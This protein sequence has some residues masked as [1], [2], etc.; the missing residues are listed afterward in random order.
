MK[1]I[2]TWLWNSENLICANFIYR[3]YSRFWFVE[4]T[5]LR[6]NLIFSIHSIYSFY[7]SHIFLIFFYIWISSHAECHFKLVSWFSYQ[8]VQKKIPKFK[9]LLNNSHMHMIERPIKVYWLTLWYIA[10]PFIKFL[11]K[12]FNIVFDFWIGV[13]D[14]NFYL[15]SL[16]NI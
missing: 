1:Y 10:C 13:V 9:C 4:K 16:L 14:K 7:L 15:F 2:L 12:F 3:Y 8:K 6:K 11:Y 5:W